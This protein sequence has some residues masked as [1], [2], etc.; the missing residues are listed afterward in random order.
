MNGIERHAALQKILDELELP[1]KVVAASVGAGV[2]RF[3]VVPAPGVSLRK[4]EKAA[5]MIAKRFHVPAVRIAVIWG[6]HRFG[7]EIPNER[8]RKVNLRNVLADAAP[9]ADKMRLPVVLGTDLKNKPVAFDLAAAPHVLVAGSDEN[10]KDAC[11]DAM[12]AG[13]VCRFAPD[14]LKFIMIDSQ[15]RNFEKYGALPHLLP[16]LAADPAEALNA[17]RWAADEIDRRNRMCIRWHV[18]TCYELIRLASEA[19][20]GKER[21]ARLPYVVVVAGELAD[22]MAGKNRRKIEMALCSVALRG[23]PAG[24]HL[25]VGTSQLRRGSLTG[26]IKAVLPTRIAFRTDTDTERLLVL[27]RRD[28]ELLTGGG[29]LLLETSDCKIT[30]V[31]CASL[32]PRELENAAYPAVRLLEETNRRQLP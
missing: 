32:P 19:E 29:D 31:Q 13:L 22:L 21:P 23:R 2:S 25:V 26:V 6:T 17:L 9:R 5:P 15:R 4:F 27:D 12:I 11:L 1:G 28:A 7:I 3:E 16:P 8:R 24:I 18:K 10:E 20:D 30:R 14:E